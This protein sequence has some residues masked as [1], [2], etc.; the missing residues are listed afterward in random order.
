MA[1][2]KIVTSPEV[3]QCQ[4]PEDRNF[5]CVAVKSS[6]PF[7]EW[8]VGNPGVNGV[9]TCGGHWDQGEDI[10]KDWKVLG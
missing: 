10:V 8:F 5:G 9:T 6:V 1:S 2:K 3:R 4:D 7:G